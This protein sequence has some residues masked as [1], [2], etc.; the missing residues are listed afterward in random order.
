[1]F[2]KEN[3]TRSRYAINSADLTKQAK[4]QR[5]LVFMLCAWF[6]NSA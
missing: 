1:M 2:F 3:S 4:D 6:G 5:N